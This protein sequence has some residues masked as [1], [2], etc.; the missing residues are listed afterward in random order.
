MNQGR[1]PHSIAT[2]W[3]E[4]LDLSL[5]TGEAPIY[6]I[7]APADALTGQSAVLALVLLEAGRK[8]LAAPRLAVGG[9]GPLWLTALWQPR[10]ANAP[11]RGRH[12]ALRGL[13]YCANPPNAALGL[14]RHK[15]HYGRRKR[16]QNHECEG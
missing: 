1:S 12:K 5:E 2:A 11:M 7:D 3:R 13:F 8:D 14:R 15:R 4:T 16:E 6:A 10:P 9:V